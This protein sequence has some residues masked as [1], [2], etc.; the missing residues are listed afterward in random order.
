MSKNSIQ[1]AP[2]TLSNRE[3]DQGQSTIFTKDSFPVLTP[4]YQANKF[5]DK[6]KTP[7]EM[8]SKYNSSRSRSYEDY[9]S[10]SNSIKELSWKQK[11]QFTCEIKSRS[12]D[13]KKPQKYIRRINFK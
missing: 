8:I 11:P 7:K 5:L 1:E 10:R 13:K 4:N 2:Q 9:S 3:D 12:P 6:V